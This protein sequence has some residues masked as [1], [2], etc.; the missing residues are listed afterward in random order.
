[1]IRGL[2]T[3]TAAVYVALSAVPGAGQSWTLTNPTGKTYENE[4]VRLKP[5]EES[6]GDEAGQVPAPSIE[7]SGP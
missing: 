6:A 7:E 3:V 2:P 5:A 4:V 1:M